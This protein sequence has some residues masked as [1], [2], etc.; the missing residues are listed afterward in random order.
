MIF[1]GMNKKQEM[2]SVKLNIS[3]ICKSLSASLVL[4]FCAWIVPSSSFAT[5]IVGGQLSYRCLDHSQYEVTLIVR[6]D[7]KNGDN[8]VY[9]DNPA[10]VG[11]FYG[12][13]QEAWRVYNGTYKMTL[14]NDDTLSESINRWCIGP[15]DEVCVNKND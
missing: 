6:R 2:E 4:L 14:I 3:K 10:L 13:N 12:D 15:N 8:D 7:C 11:I 9:F 1:C 5:H